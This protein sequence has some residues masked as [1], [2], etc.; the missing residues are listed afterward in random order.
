MAQDNYWQTLNGV[1]RIKTP[2]G[3]YE[4]GRMISQMDKTRNPIKSDILFDFNNDGKD[5]LK[6]HEKGDKISVFTRDNSVVDAKWKQ[7]QEYGLTLGDIYRKIIPLLNKD[8]AIKISPVEI[9]PVEETKIMPKEGDAKKLESIDEKEKMVI[10]QVK[11]MLKKHEKFMPFVYE[12]DRGSRTIGYGHKFLPSDKEKYKNI[13]VIRDKKERLKIA[14]DS[15]YR[16]LMM[17]KYSNHLSEAKAEE[18]LAEDVKREYE[19]MKK[20]VGVEVIEMLNAKQL[21]ALTSLTFN[22][23]LDTKCPKLVQYLKAAAKEQNPGQRKELLFKAQAEF[24]AFKAG[25]TYCSGLVRRRIEE[26]LLFMDGEVCDEAKQTILKGINKCKKLTKG[27]HFK[28]LE[29]DYNSPEIKDIEL[30]ELLKQVLKLQ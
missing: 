3:E 7:T 29:A 24:D 30:K 22:C 13:K 25:N 11:S 10:T 6:I 17:E 1:I 19:K 20:V 8:N 18:L 21:E 2:N 26:M 9:S 5:D 23:P 12:C 4:Y 28:N 14:H 16:A 27:K 15:E